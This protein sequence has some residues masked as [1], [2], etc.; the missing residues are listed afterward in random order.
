MQTTL[1]ERNRVEGMAMTMTMAAASFCCYSNH[2]SIISHSLQSLR[3]P[4]LQLPRI[5]ILNANYPLSRRLAS[6]AK[7]PACENKRRHIQCSYSTES[8]SGL[9]YSS[10]PIDVVA[11]VKTEKIIVFG[12]SGFVGSAICKAAVARGIE[13]VSLSRSG[14]PPYVDSWVDQVTWVAGDVF[15]AEWDGLLRGATAVVSTLGGF[16]TNE[17]MEKINGEANVLAVDAASKAG[18]PKFILI[19]VH[20]YNLPSFLLNSGYFSGKRRA[21]T[22]VL[23]KYPNSGTV[24]RPGFI[25]GKRK[26]NGFEIPLDLIGQPL[27]K[28]L[29]A[30][31]NFTRVLSSLPGSDLFLAPPV[32]VDDVASA[33]I[34]AV[35]DDSV[36]G[37]FTIEQIKEAAAVVRS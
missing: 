12:G 8:S 17:Q 18:I 13:A 23:S 7:L 21:E 3:G 28:F 34:N 2:S 10:V 14:R 26:V 31:E 19:S 22:E 36:F 37:I 30:S 5:S 6:H 1:A 35:T 24:L 15:Y 11:D 25:Y 9:D 16:G 33:V 27:E 4:R 32:S 20:D 29:L